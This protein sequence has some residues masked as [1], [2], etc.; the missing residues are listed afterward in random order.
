M[1]SECSNRC[2]RGYHAIKDSSLCE[3][4]KD[5]VDNIDSLDCDNSMIQHFYD[6]IKIKFNIPCEIGLLFVEKITMAHMFKIIKPR[7]EPMNDLTNSKLLLYQWIKPMYLDIPEIENIGFI[8][9]PLAKLSKSI[10]P[11][12]KIYYLQEFIERL[13]LQI[14]KIS[15]HDVFFPN[16]IYC[17]IKANIKDIFVH[18][19]ILKTFRRKHYLKCSLFC[20]HGFNEPVGCDCLVSKFWDQES[21]YYVTTCIAAV[22]YIS[23]MEYYSLNV[24]SKVFDEEIIK[25]LE[26]FVLQDRNDSNPVIKKNQ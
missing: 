6:Y 8:I 20:N 3:I 5:F 12:V 7:V 21:E 13:Y 17:F 10:V 19:Y 15:G 16:I 2:I 22:D 14:G 23:K 26:G 4:I 1:K 18:L 9:E 11:S 25:K 24:D